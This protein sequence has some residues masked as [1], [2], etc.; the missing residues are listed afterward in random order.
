[1]VQTTLYYSV[2]TSGTQQV[3]LLDLSGKVIKHYR[4]YQSAPGYYSFDF[5]TSELQPGVYVCKFM[6]REGTLTAKLVK[7]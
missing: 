5:S 3:F 4:L 1:M 7:V 6:T 2:V